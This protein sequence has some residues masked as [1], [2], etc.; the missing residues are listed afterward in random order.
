ME[1]TALYKLKNTPNN[2]DVKIVVQTQNNIY[3]IT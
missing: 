1:V 2:I 3:I